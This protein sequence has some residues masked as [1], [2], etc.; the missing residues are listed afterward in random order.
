[1]SARNGDVPPQSISG[2]HDS[3]GPTY[4]ARARL[5]NALLPGK[6]VP[7]HRACYVPW[8]AKKHKLD[9]YEVLCGNGEWKKTSGN[10]IPKKAIHGGMTE[11]GEVLYVGRVIHNGIYTSGKIQPSHGCIYVPYG[12]LEWRYH[13]YEIY[14]SK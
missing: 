5:G 3:G 9:T 12:G 14:V 6:L 11:N 13:N 10:N 8:E 7:A 2:G 4:V 1:M